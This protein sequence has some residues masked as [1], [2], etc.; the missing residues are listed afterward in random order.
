MSGRRVVRTGAPGQRCRAKVR[1]EDAAARAGRAQGYARR[2]AGRSFPRVDSRCMRRRHV[3]VV[4]QRFAGKFR[5]A[6]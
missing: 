1:Q 3:E 5:A 6:C 4:S 2:M